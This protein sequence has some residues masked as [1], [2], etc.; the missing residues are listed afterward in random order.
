M[1][2]VGGVEVLPVNSIQTVRFISR[3]HNVLNYFVVHF[4]LFKCFEL[5]FFV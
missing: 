1:E 2:L 5:C 3:H 4:A